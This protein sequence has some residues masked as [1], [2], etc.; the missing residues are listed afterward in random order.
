M[1]DR[2][3]DDYDL[4]QLLHSGAGVQTPPPRLSTIRT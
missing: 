4:N 2:T 3:R 1:N